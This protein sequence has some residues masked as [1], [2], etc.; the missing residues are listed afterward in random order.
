[1]DD[2]RAF[3]D[4]TGPVLAIVDD[5]QA[6]DAVAR[7]AF[8]RLTTRQLSDV[9]YRRLLADERARQAARGGQTGVQ[10]KAA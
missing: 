9:I 6:L 3:A 4:L 2:V 1:V 7:T 5:S 8:K 10:P